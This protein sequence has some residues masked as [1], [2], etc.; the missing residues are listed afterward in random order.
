MAMLVGK[1]NLLATSDS[2]ASSKLPNA[3]AQLQDANKRGKPCWATKK[4]WATHRKRIEELYKETTLTE[5]M[6]IMKTRHGITA[7]Y[8]VGSPKN[9]VIANLIHRKKMYQSQ[10]AAWGLGKKNRENEMRAIVRK[11][12]QR[13]DAGKAST[14]RVRGKV[15]DDQE[16]ARYFAR[17]KNM[18]MID[19]IERN[20]S[21]P[22]PGVIECVTPLPSPI[23]TP[24]V[25]AIPEEIHVLIRDYY[26]SSLEI[27][28][29]GHSYVPPMSCYSFKV[30]ESTQY[31][32]L[33]F[34]HQE[35][36]AACELFSYHQF[37][38]AGQTLIAATSMVK[39]VIEDQTP[40]L[41][42]YLLVVVLDINDKGKHEIALAIIK[43]FHD[44][45]EILLSESHPIRRVCRRLLCM[46][47]LQLHDIATKAIGGV[48]DRFESLFGPLHAATLLSRGRYLRAACGRFNKNYEVV[49]IQQ[50]LR[51]CEESLGPWDTRTLSLR[52]HLADAFREDNKYQECA[53]T[54]NGILSSLALFDNDQF[55]CFIEFEALYLAAFCLYKLRDYGAAE[56]LIRKAINLRMSNW[57]T[58]DA[59]ARMWLIDLEAIL[60]GAGKSDDAL[61]IRMWRQQILDSINKE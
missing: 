60:I 49:A 34:L 6:R 57:G 37:K 26:S 43:T 15:I 16:I 51:S 3:N 48:V 28:M 9:L 39:N 36:L 7:T 56:S 35:T 2:F 41:L 27:G 42:I 19:V 53:Q 33:Y 29:Q 38:E 32:A 13:A 10:I 23:A 45:S 59:R 30:N 21:S 61:S 18:T 14:F 52:L 55:A 12:K 40:Q 58:Q 50:M 22:T 46:Q 17:K 31:D 4:D 47:T 24:A 8:V 1:S 5:M 20:R 44:F 54:I 25:L 11:G